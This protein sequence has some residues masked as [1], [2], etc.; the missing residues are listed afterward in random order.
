LSAMEIADLE[1]FKTD[2]ITAQLRLDLP[3]QAE[4]QRIEY[5]N[6][7]KIFL[8]DYMVLDLEIN[9]GKLNFNRFIDEFSEKLFLWKSKEN[10]ERI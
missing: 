2:S 3:N 1:K 6:L 8:E 5:I 10:K 4:Y 7:I 9:G